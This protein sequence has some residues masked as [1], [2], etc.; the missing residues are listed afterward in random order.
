MLKF[1]SLDDILDFA[2]LQEKAAQQFYSK[3]SGMV[4]NPQV[5]LF[6][7]TLV[8]EESL[9]EQKLVRLKG[10]GYQLKDAD[11]TMLRESGYLSAMPCAPE[12]TLVE[13]IRFS[14]RKEKSSRILYALLAERMQDNKELAELFQML[15]EQEQLHAEYFEGELK[16][17]TSTP[18]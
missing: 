10:C 12:I 3:L 15:A 4:K 8:E 7:R 18:D 5:S 17:Q 13:A 11:L 6:Y 16:R 14:V 1:E 2:I 9:H